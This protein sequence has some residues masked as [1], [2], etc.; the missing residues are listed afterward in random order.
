MLDLKHDTEQPLYTIGR[1]AEMT[2][3]APSTLRAWE[4]AYGLLHPA[5]SEGGT[6]IYTAGDVDLVHQIKELQQKEHLGL[7]VIAS[8][9]GVNGAAETAPSKRGQPST[10]NPEELARLFALAK[11]AGVAIENARL[12][13]KERHRSAVFLAITA[14]QHRLTTAMSRDAVFPFVAEVIQKEL[15]FPLVNIFSLVPGEDKLRLLAA[16]G[17]LAPK[18][19]VEVILRLSQRGPNERAARSG[20]PQLQPDLRRAR[21]QEMGRLFPRSR[22]ELV[23][24]ILLRDRVLGTLDVHRTVPGAFEEADLL[25]LQILAEQVA[26]VLE[27]NAT[28]SNLQKVNRQ[29]LA[30]LEVSTALSAELH[31]EKLL[32]MIVSHAGELS[33]AETVAVPVRQCCA[34]EETVRYVAAWGRHADVLRGL[35]VPLAQAGFCGWVISHQEPLLTDRAQR[36]PR[37]NKDLLL[38]LKVKTALVVPMVSPSGVEGG[39]TSLN[40][41]DGGS[42]TLQDQQLLHLLANHAAVAMRNSRFLGEE[43]GFPYREGGNKECAIR[44][45]S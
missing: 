15:G 14:L 16:A 20:K 36:D 18:E 6:R 4:D 30:A 24:P 12:L 13:V 11:D 3:V 34:G 5:R 42:F 41:R 22:S 35:E 21:H 40:K 37:A 23:V 39:L 8:L 33:G 25:A 43:K 45:V 9:L 19:T 27:A 2:G 28:F 1:V 38:R 31:P 44:P 29:L 7:Q 17:E 32:E 10:I 26:L